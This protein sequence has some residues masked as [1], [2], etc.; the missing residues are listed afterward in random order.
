MYDLAVVGGKT[1]TPAGWR[2]LDV[3]V[4]GGRIAALAR[5][6]RRQRH[7]CRQVLDARDCLVLPGAIDP[8]VH[9][10]LTI[11]P[12]MT[13][14]DDFSSGTRAAAARVPAGDGKRS[15]RRERTREGA[16]AHGLPRP[17]AMA[18]RGAGDA[19]LPLQPRGW[20]TT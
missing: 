4:R 5:L 3:A 15:P 10:S 6:S 19:P 9:L 17:G 7:L 12:G 8:H 16:R 14:A 13:T 1:L 20:R 18:G 2:R 11:G